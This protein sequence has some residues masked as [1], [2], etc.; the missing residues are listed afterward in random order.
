MLSKYALS[1]LV[2]VLLISAAYSVDVQP[3]AVPPIA[4]VEMAKILPAAESVKSD[5]H[6]KKPHMIGGDGHDYRHSELQKT[7]EHLI[8]GKDDVSSKYFD[9][10]KQNKEKEHLLGDDHDKADKS[11]QQ[12]KEKVEEKTDV[13]KEKLGEAVNKVPSF[14]QSIFGSGTAQAEQKMGDFEQI[15]KDK[16]AQQKSGNGFFSILFLS[17]KKA[18]GAL[19]G[20]EAEPQM[21]PKTQSLILFKINPKKEDGIDMP[22]NNLHL[23]GGGDQDI[24]DKFFKPQHVLGG[25]EDVADKMHISGQMTGVGDGDVERPQ[26]IIPQIPF[27]N[28]F[29]NGKRPYLIP[30]D[31]RERT[32]SDESDSDSDEQKTPMQLL[33]PSRNDQ[34]QQTEFSIRSPEAVKKCMM[35]HFM[36]LKASM[37]YRTVLH[38]L[39][40]SGILLFAFLVCMIIMRT[41]KRRREMRFKEGEMN[42]SAIETKLAMAGPPAY[43]VLEK[44]DEC[45]PHP[46]HHHPHHH[47][48]HH[49]H[50]HPCTPDEQSA[51]KSI[52][53]AANSPSSLMNSLAQAYRNRYTVLV[54]A[55]PT[56]VE[57][58]NVS[59]SSLPN[60]E[61]H[62]AKLKNEMA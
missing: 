61:E 59:V 45:H 23:L 40:I 14:L 44:K 8:G 56:A 12:I 41:C 47:H 15:I 25:D 55:K 43:E 30:K 11:I 58:D 60:Y 4:P 20:S 54:G 2:C 48:H 31:E 37:Y 35:Q 13:I 33:L 27:F 39:F 18:D 1:S 42:V 50:P 34:L 46:H 29:L 28:Y 5:E 10:Q 36:R 24:D 57:A 52:F 9:L 38:M 62:Q 32:D 53:R 22:F 3:Q 7:K 6:H 49:P 17:K 19:P 21:S 16:M 26:A 51:V